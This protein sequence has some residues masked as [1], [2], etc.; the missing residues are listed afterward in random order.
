MLGAT[1]RRFER[2]EALPALA[3]A[4]LLLLWAVPAMID[5]SPD[6]LRV[7]HAGG[8]AAWQTGHPEQARDWLSTSFLALVMGL[9]SRVASLKA[10]TVALNTLN[11]LLVLGTLAVVWSWLRG[12]LRPLLWWATLGCAVSYSPILSTIRWKQLNLI[13]LVLAMVGFA[14]IRRGRWPWG[15]AAVGLS[16]ALKPLVIVLPLALLARRDT[17]TAGASCLA[18]AAALTFLGQGFLALRAHDAALLSPVSVFQNF[19]RRATAFQSEPENLSPQALV[20]NLTR[21]ND[22]VQRGVVLLGVVV[23]LL[24]A[25]ESLRRSP[26]K[27]WEIFAFAL[28]FSTLVGPISWS[29]YQV[30]LLPMFVLLAYEFSLEGAGSAFWIAL[31]FAYVLAC[32]TQRPLEFTVPGAL[33]ALFTGRPE[34]WADVT[35]TLALSQFAPYFLYAAALGWFNRKLVSS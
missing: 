8:T 10:A 30:L 19:S 24:L 11:M 34:R 7:L 4:G 29:H 33:R 26:G 32:L 15:P 9:V 22:A 28:L 6:D 18:V 23:A 1:D 35:Q 2:W 20:Q 31:V 13:V 21:R 27:S 16:L 17:R 25:N 12:R 14:L 5:V 3:V